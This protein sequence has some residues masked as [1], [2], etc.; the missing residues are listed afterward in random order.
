MDQ[1]TVILKLI[2][3]LICALNQQPKHLNTVPPR[4]LRAFLIDLWCFFFSIF[5]FYYSKVNTEI[6]IP[7]GNSYGKIVL[8][9]PRR[10]F[11]SQEVSQPTDAESRVKAGN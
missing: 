11:W 5:Y 8:W 4:R 9:H 3:V 7:S 10:D 6:R 1:Y 2:Q